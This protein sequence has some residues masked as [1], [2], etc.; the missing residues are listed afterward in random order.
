[1][2]LPLFISLKNH[3]YSYFVPKVVYEDTETIARRYNIEVERK[4]KNK[5]KNMKWS[6]RLVQKYSL[7]GP[8]F[9]S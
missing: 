8:P 4:N 2:K 6:L 7:R 5:D 1:M 9:D 3:F